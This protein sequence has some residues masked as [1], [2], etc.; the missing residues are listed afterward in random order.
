M[1]V[2]LL[3]LLLLLLYNVLLTQSLCQSCWA[4]GSQAP[5]AAQH[6]GLNLARQA[7]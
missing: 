3:L 7:Q 4:G 1:T 6:R 2:W 5:A